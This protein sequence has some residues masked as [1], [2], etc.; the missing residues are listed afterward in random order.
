MQV[1]CLPNSM[2][3]K[4]MKV[5]TSHWNCRRVDRGTETDEHVFSGVLIKG[6]SIKKITEC[7][8]ALYINVYE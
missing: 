5:P 6:Y 1:N 2:N 7:W 8:K 3:I 4:R